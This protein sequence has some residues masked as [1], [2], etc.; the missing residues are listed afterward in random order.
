M[1]NVF[2]NESVTSQA[3]QRN[4][5][6]QSSTWRGASWGDYRRQVAM[7]QTWRHDVSWGNWKSSVIVGR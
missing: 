4:A 7:V 3:R 5:V 2:D 1:I 6:I